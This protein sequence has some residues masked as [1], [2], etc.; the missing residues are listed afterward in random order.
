MVVGII[1]V[2]LVAWALLGAV[3]TVLRT[4]E[5]IAVAAVAGWVGYRVGHYRGRRAAERRDR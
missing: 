4:L 5:L 1:V 3:F 2:A